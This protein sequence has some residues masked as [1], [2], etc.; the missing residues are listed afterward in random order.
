MHRAGVE[1]VAEQVAA[2]CVVHLLAAGG[3][4]RLGRGEPGEV[5]GAGGDA[6]AGVGGRDTHDRRAGLDLHL[7]GGFHRCD[8]A[9]ERCGDGVLHLHALDDRQRVALGDPVA[10]LDEHRQH[11][12]RPAATHDAA[13]VAE[14]RVGGAVDVDPDRG[15]LHHGHHA[16][17][18]A[19]DGDPALE[20]V[21]VGDHDVC[22]GDAGGHAVRMGAGAVDVQVVLLAAVAQPAAVPDAGRRLGAAAG[23][24]G[25]ERGLFG[26]LVEVVG[27][28]RGHQQRHRIGSGQVRR[29]AGQP[30]Q[31]VGVE[32]PGAHLRPVEQRQQ[33]RPVRG[34]AFDHRGGFSQ[35]SAQPRHRLVAVTAPGDD[36]GDHRVEVGR[37]PVAFAEPRVDADAGAG[38][39]AQA[40]QPAGCGRE[41]VL[42]VLGV[43]PRLDRVAG[44]R[45]L[46]RGQPAA[47]RDVQLHLDQVH[48]G[49]DL[50]DRV[51]DLQS[52]VD[53]HEL[54]AA[55][56]GVDEE[57]HGAGVVV[58]GGGGQPHGRVADRLLLGGVEH[59]R[60]RLL[61]H[62]LVSAL[63]AAVPDADRPDRAVA[64]GDHL[65]L[66]VPGGRH[67]L[68]QEDRRVAERQRRLGPRRRQRGGELVVVED[69]PDAAPAAARGRLDHHRVAE[70][71]RRAPW[72]PRCPR[73]VRRSTAPPGR[74]PVRRPAWRPP[75]RRAGGSWRCPGRRT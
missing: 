63:Q 41:P 35:R 11:E 14:H 59:R 28:D 62:L 5:D 17:R 58:A 22:G 64:V 18:P 12:R 60:R 25:V 45:R 52:G 65:H 6:L 26:G 7:G 49:G 21:P 9:G 42:G 32:L 37:N 50:G 74:R 61:E 56:R 16:M 29:L 34:A 24:A 43:Q 19:A 70:L 75:C 46:L 71:W 55:R 36:L 1:V 48:P 33:E 57:L 31:P 10:G 66:D 54:E 51:L 67:Q 39:H 40:S 38:G 15:T 20:A 30:V 72:P 13:V 3:A 4:G 53:L 73:P 47:L 68:L 2:Q 27:L 69:H 44:H 23:R 8:G